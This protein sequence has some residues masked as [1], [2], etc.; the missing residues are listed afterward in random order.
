MLGR[1]RRSPASRNEPAIDILLEVDREYREKAGD[2]RLPLITPRR[3]NPTN[4][5]WLPVLHTA[6]RAW[7]FTALFSNTALAHSLGRTNDWVVIYFNTNSYGE[8]QRTVVTETRGPFK[9]KRMVRGR[10][11]ECE[12]YYRALWAAEDVVA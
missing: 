1:R 11:S 3:F 10:E 4:E 9:G 12:E 6:R 8:G 7:Q 5:P 2:H